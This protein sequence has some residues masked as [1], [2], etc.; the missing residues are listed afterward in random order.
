MNNKNDKLDNRKDYRNNAFT[1]WAFIKLTFQCNYFN[2]SA[3]DSAQTFRSLN[4]IANTTEFQDLL[5]QMSFLEIQ[6]PHQSLCS[7]LTFSVGPNVL[8]WKMNSPRTFYFLK[9]LCKLINFTL[10]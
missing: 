2:I 7:R 9:K 6:E 10:V 8:D 5:L 4:W 1:Y 3:S